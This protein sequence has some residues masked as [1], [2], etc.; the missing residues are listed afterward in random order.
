MTFDLSRHCNTGDPI[1]LISKKEL[2]QRLNVSERTIH[3][4][5][6]AKRLPE[7]MRTEHGNNGGW[8]TS[9][10]NCWLSVKQGH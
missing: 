9:T 8:L 1:R 6:K 7:P 10:I 4:W 3:R 2:A 5:I